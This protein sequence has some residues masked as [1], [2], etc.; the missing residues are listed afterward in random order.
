MSFSH[1][2]FGRGIQFLCS[3]CFHE[4]SYI[5]S[6]HLPPS[7]DV[8]TSSTPAHPLN[9]SSIAWTT[10]CT[11]VPVSSMFWLVLSA[12]NMSMSLR[13]R[14]FSLHPHFNMWC[15]GDRPYARVD[16]SWSSLVTR[17]QPEHAQIRHCRSYSWHGHD[18]RHAP[19]SRIHFR[20]Q[21]VHEV[22]TERT[23]ALHTTRTRIPCDPCPS[24][25]TPCS[26]PCQTQ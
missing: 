9:C 14:A 23:L 10:C 11:H 20:C 13:A 17:G 6:S 25:C 3:C 1:F 24:C 16:K 22:S 15:I 26:D 8:S 7:S 4:Q 18:H 21:F 12:S 19:H 2:L 5:S